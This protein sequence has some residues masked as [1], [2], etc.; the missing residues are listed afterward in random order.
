M[1]NYKQEKLK[2][3]LEK[4]AQKIDKL[5]AGEKEVYIANLTQEIRLLQAQLKDSAE[6]KERLDNNPNK[7]PMSTNAVSSYLTVSTIVG[8]LAGVGIGVSIEEVVMFVLGPAAGFVLGIANGVAYEE[9]PI[10]N[11]V[12]QFRKYL[13][14][15]KQE[16][17]EDEI[18]SKMYLRKQLGEMEL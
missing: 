11:K 18:S 5:P 17:L 8:L 1:N 2:I 16:R 13:N 7:R 9:K 10:S 14:G 3:K 4:L 12:N 15:K 6:H